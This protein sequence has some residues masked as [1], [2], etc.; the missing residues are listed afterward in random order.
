MAVRGWRRGSTD[1]KTASM[2]G[3]VGFAAG[4]VL[5]TL[6]GTAGSAPPDDAWRLAGTVVGV[7]AVRAVVETP[8]GV[9]HAVTV[10]GHIGDCVLR[11]VM[12][13][14]ARFDCGTGVRG[15]TLR[16]GDGVLAEQRRS[17]RLAI[18]GDRF[19]AL[20]ADRQRLVGEVS[21]KPRVREGRID[22]WAVDSLRED[23]MLAGYGLRAGDVIIALDGT[24][25]AQPDALMGV[26]HG[27]E[28][29]NGFA[30]QLER[31]DEPLE[32]QVSLY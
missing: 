10:G 22:G 20:L 6:S 23:G 7:P 28:G 30:L 12:L 3:A 24:P 8:D 5:L 27:L 19:R 11:E 1:S 2:R 17:Q 26:L 16:Q 21:L 14:S 29:A 13:D 9:Q 18:P 15:L 31:D 4:A 25:V 32:L